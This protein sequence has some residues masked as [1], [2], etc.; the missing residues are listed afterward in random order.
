MDKQPIDLGFILKQFPNFDFSMKTLDDRIKLQK[1]IYLLQTFDIYLGYDFSWYIHGPYCST[2]STCGFALTEF[3]DTIPDKKTQFVNKESQDKFEI[4][5]Q[6]I[7]GRE[8]DMTFLEIAASLHYQKHV[9]KLSDEDAIKK[10]EQKRESFTAKQ[11]K[12]VWD[13]LK[14]WNL[15]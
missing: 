9:K 8:T 3:Y 7:Q 1:F 2:L 12:E 4:F 15:L 13:L 5:Q 11:C 10:V 6:F 14:T